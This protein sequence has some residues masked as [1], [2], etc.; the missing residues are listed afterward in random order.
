[1]TKPGKRGPFENY[2][3]CFSEAG[4]ELFVA[5]FAN[6]SWTLSGSE[7]TPDL[8]LERVG[9][10]GCRWNVVHEGRSFREE[11]IGE[12]LGITIRSAVIP[13]SHIVVYSD[14]TLVYLALAFG[15]LTNHCPG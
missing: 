5:Q 9:I 10:L 4:K 7:A 3:L 11:S 12:E 1:M 14:E 8:S 13:D 2:R 6:R 15:S